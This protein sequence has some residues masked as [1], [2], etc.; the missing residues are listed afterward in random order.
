MQSNCNREFRYVTG[1]KR[2]HFL[3]LEAVISIDMNN[4]NNII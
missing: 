2:I 3:T 4:D 1:K